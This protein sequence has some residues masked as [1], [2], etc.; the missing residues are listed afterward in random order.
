MNDD[1]LLYT[2]NNP[3]QHIESM[4]KEVREKAYRAAGMLKES[5][6]QNLALEAK[7]KELEAIIVELQKALEEKTLEM[8]Q[9]QENMKSSSA[10]DVGERLL[11][12][13]PDEREAL[14]RQIND[15]LARVSSHLR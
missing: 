8:K 1:Q 6:L 12:F 4:V 5:R 2:E 9:L 11:Y 15:L 13:S 3:F 10:I 14:E 7:N